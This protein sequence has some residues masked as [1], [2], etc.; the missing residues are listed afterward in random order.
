MKQQHVEHSSSETPPTVLKGIGV[1]PGIVVGRIVYVDDDPHRVLRRTL[2]AASAKGELARFETALKAS[3]DEI[4]SVHRQAEKEMGK[5]AANIFR[6]H[7]GMLADK[8]LLAPIRKLIETDHVNAEYAVSHVFAQLAARFLANPDSVFATKANDVDDL[9]SRLIGHL[10]GRHDLRLKN[11][12]PDTVLFAGDLTP[13][14]T[15]AFDRSKVVGFATALGGRTGHTSIVAKA[16]GIPAVV[17]CRTLL[18]EDGATVILDG[19]EGVVIINPS[20]EQLV[21]YKRLVEQ[22]RTYQL[23]LSDLA[24]APAVTTDG[25]EI[26]LLGNIEFPDE[27]KSVIAAGGTG[28]GLY[29]TEFLHLTR[30]TEPTEGDHFQAYKRCVEQLGGRSLTIRTLDLGADK[31]TQ[32]QAEAPE[33]NPFLGLRS[34]RYCLAHQPMFKKQL[35][36]ILRASGL[37]GMSPGQLKVMFPLVTS[38]GEFRQAKYL[39]N[40]VMEDLSEEGHAFDRSVKLGM[41][42]E[43]PS[44]AILA[45]IFAAEVDFFSIGTNDLVQYTLAVDRTNE[46]L[47][48]M[49]NPHHPAVLHLIRDVVK[50]ARRHKIPVSCCGEQAAEVEYAVLLLGMG[51]RTLSVTASSIPRLKRLVRSVSAQACQRIASHALQ[52]DSDVQVAS[53]TRDRLRKLVPEAYEGRRAE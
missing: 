28:I 22:R 41:M 40:D 30:P 7:L 33:R 45:D 38:I 51:V 25:V 1:S 52:L 15:A 24:G 2:P 26:E 18:A 20:P 10:M 17:G 36:A 31:H 39:V 14:Q 48:H 16:L 19:D 21:E 23:S 49:Y 37:P 34:I 46:R 11:L 13:S 5:E 42:V 53:Y 44:A 35:R 8:N 29:R 9:S 32:A 47:A 4:N 50:A 43:V 6:F 12:P 3:V 27:V